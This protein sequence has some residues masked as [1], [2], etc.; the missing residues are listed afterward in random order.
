MRR[1]EVSL[2]EM[3][4]VA[5]TRAMAGAGMALLLADCVK[6]ATRKTLGVTLLALGALTTV[7]IALAVA[8]RSRPLPRDERSPALQE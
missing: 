6:P 3:A 8:A 5:G 7:P 2:S 1:F 4:F